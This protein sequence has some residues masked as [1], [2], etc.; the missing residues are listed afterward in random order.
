MNILVAAILLV[1]QEEMERLRKDLEESKRKQ[2]E[3]EQRLDALD[4]KQEPKEKQAETIFDEGFWFVGKDDKL[5]VGGTGQLDGRFFL[6]NEDGDSNFLVR[7]ARIFGTGV[8]EE[9][10]GYMVMGRWDQQTPALHF[11][12]LESQHLPWARFRVGLFKEPFSMEGLHSDQYWDFV[13]RSLGVSNFLQLED[14]GAMLYGKFWDDR[15]EYGVGVFNGRGRSLENNADKEYVA[16]IVVAP[17]HKAVDVLDHFY[18]GVS[19]S[20]GGQKETLSG[21]TFKTGAGTN[22]WTWA[23]TTTVEDDRVRWGVDLEWL[24]GSA[25]IRAEYIDVDWG[26]VVRGAA[27]DRFTGSGWFVE[28]A[29]VLTGEKKRRNKPVLPETNFAPADGAW[30]AWELAARYEELKLDEGA[31]SQGMATGTDEVNGITLGVNWY[32]NRHMA[33]KMDWHHLW[34]DDAIGGNDDESVLTLRFQF[35]F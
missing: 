9:K 2:A 32:P 18:V 27:I 10:F 11:A 12:W 26:D 22:V 3:M 28:G 23:T 35:E 14:I 17:F 31:L 16:R 6:E 5:R 20:I 24:F 33:V 13:E 34:F 19:G 4:P 8:L 1:Q 15:I 21:T 25:A 29:Y 30:G 7:R